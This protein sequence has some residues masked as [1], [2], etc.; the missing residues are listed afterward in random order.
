MPGRGI[1]ALRRGRLGGDVAVDPDAD[2]V[3]GRL[4]GDGVAAYGS[5]PAQEADESRFR[6]VRFRAAG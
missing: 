5:Q 6:G 1:A 2:A 3:S 4:V